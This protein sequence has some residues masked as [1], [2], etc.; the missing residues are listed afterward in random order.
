MTA[1]SAERVDSKR[2][3]GSLRSYAVAA[4]TT[5]YKGAMVAT[6]SS[7]YLVPASTATTLTVLGVAMENGNNA[8]GS[9]GDI[10]CQ[11]WVKGVWQMKNSADS[12]EITIAEIGDACYAVDDQTVAKTDGGTTRSVAGVI[13]D[14]DSDGVWVQFG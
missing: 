10:E 4:S 8:S 3:D 9:A 7:G 5:I 12:D 14:V 1:L 6:N 2:R 13:D 11:V